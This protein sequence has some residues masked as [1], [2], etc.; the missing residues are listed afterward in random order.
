MFL[1]KTIAKYLRQAN[2][3]SPK[4]NTFKKT[5]F[6]DFRAEVIMLITALH[7]VAALYASMSYM[8]R[9]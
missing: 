8:Q 2:D 7:K 5:T 9:R 4:K 1:A 3:V 6:Q